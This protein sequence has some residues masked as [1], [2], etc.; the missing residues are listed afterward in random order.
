MVQRFH[1]RWPSDRKYP[2]VWVHLQAAVALAGE[3]HWRMDRRRQVGEEV[4]HLILMHL[5]IAE[6]P[7]GH[8]GRPILMQI[9]EERQLG[10]HRPR[11]EHLTPTPATDR[12]L[13]P[14]TLQ[15]HRIRTLL[16][17]VG[18]LLGIRLAHRH[19]VLIMMLGARQ[20]TVMG[21]VVVVEVVAE[22]RGDLIIMNPV[23]G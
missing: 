5:V 4:V 10:L 2:Q 9:V 7:P 16:R 8:L 23:L 11:H 12:K 6:H 14:G 19:I 17:V 3:R 1:L 18:H 20:I 21:G 13:L 15:G 22:V